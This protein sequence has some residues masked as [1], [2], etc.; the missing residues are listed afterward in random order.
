M[1][2]QTVT[3]E[4]RPM[5]Y[6]TRSATMEPKEIAAAMGDAF[7]AIG[8]F[9]GK[10]GVKPAGP[11]LAVYHDWDETSGKMKIDLGF[12]VAST[13]TPKAAGEVHAGET[14]HGKALK[15]V[16]HGPYPKLR[17]TYGKLEEQ[18]KKAGI[19]MPKSAWEVYVSDPDTTPE[20]DLV[21]EIYMPVS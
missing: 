5:L 2:T 13:D 11:A 6:V 7:G 15:A 14:P 3:A 10:S 20:K 8:A 19:P 17:E 18:M 9:L 1:K 4:S 16:H 12:P 21:T